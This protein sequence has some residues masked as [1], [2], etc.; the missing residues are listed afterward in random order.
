MTPVNGF[1]VK[2]GR[3]KNQIYLKSFCII[4]GERDKVKKTSGVTW[5]R[6]WMFYA[7]IYATHGLGFDS[8]CLNTGT[9]HSI[10]T[11]C[12]CKKIS[13]MKI[14][15]IYTTESAIIYESSGL[16]V[17]RVDSSRTDY[18]HYK[19]IH[20]KIMNGIISVQL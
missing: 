10:I 18:Y 13:F 11:R 1:T 7:C 15:V 9:V 2:Y 4:E 17:V 20:S 5:W 16:K 14:V 19:W 12:H 3:N 6:Q 8:C